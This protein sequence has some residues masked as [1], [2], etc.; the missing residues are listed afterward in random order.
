MYNLTFWS[1]CQFFFKNIGSLRFI[2]KIKGLPWLKWKSQFINNHSQEKPNIPED[3]LEVQ[4]EFLSKKVSKKLDFDLLDETGTIVF[5]QGEL[6]DEFA[7]EAIK[8]NGKKV[9][10]RI[11]DPSVSEKSVITEEVI[12]EMTETTS[13]IFNE[14]KTSGILSKEA[15]G[16]SRKQYDNLVSNLSYYDVKDCNLILDNEMKNLD[17]FFYRH[18]VNTGCLSMIYGMKLRI[19]KEQVLDLIQAAYY[20]DV[21]INKIPHEI[22]YKNEALT[23]KE[24]EILQAHTRIGYNIIHNYSLE[25]PEDMSAINAKLTALLHHRKYNDQGYPSDKILGDMGVKMPYRALPQFTKI[26]SVCDTYTA[27]TEARPFRPAFP[28]DKVLRIILNQSLQAFGINEVQDFI[29]HMA[30]P[31]N[32][33][34]I[35]YSEDHLLVLLSELTTS[36]GWSFFLL[37]Y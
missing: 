12:E 5:K 31:L 30:F 37:G 29:K 22:L 10:K 6:L 19:P 14:I 8:K 17:D 9:Y 1:Y 33:R 36:K 3:F 32:N 26:T 34:K 25:N 13:E 2:G 11:F 4:L 21:G 16:H 15:F 7:I 23:P 27:L 24:N 18:S 35:F 20:F 28:S